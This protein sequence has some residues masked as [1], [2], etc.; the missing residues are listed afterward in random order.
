MT[1]IARL[2][3]NLAALHEELRGLRRE[4]DGIARLER[5]ATVQDVLDQLAP[6]IAALGRLEAGDDDGSGRDLAARLAECLLAIG[7]RRTGTP[8]DVVD[9]WPDEATEDVELDRSI[10]RTATMVCVE[11][12]STGWASGHK[13]IAR[14]R[15]RVV[16][17]VDDPEL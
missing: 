8:G 14:P 5:E 17:V 13:V 1:D 4:V 10:P 9:L 7:L 15:G 16:E 2:E 11:I 3:R 12:V 6:A